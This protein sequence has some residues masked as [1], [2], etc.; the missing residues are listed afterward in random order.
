M[1]KSDRIES[2]VSNFLSVDPTSGGSFNN[3]AVLVSY[4]SLRSKLAPYVDDFIEEHLDTRIVE[5]AGLAA[6]GRFI[7]TAAFTVGAFKK[8]YGGKDVDK[9]NEDELRKLLKDFLYSE[10]KTFNPD[11]SFSGRF[12]R[13]CE[14]MFLGI[15]SV[16]F[17]D[18]RMWTW[19]LDKT[20]LTPHEFVKYLEERHVLNEVVA[21]LFPSIE[22]DR[23]TTDSTDEV[24]NFGD[25]VKRRNGCSERIRAFLMSM[26]DDGT[27]TLVTQTI[28]SSLTEWFEN[29]TNSPI[30]LVPENRRLGVVSKLVSRMRPTDWC[31]P[32]DYDRI[33]GWGLDRTKNSF[34]IKSGNV[35]SELGE[36]SFECVFNIGPFDGTANDSSKGIWFTSQDRRQAD[37]VVQNEKDLLKF[38]TK[39]GVDEFGDNGFFNTFGV[40]SKGRYESSDVV[41]LYGYVLPWMEMPKNDEPYVSPNEYM[42]RTG[43]TASI[44]KF[45]VIAME[46]IDGKWKAYDKFCDYV[47][48]C[49]RSNVD[50]LVEYADGVYKALVDAEFIKES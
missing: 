4:L 35:V 12:D 9:L 20:V 49:Y 46:G 18:K 21:R 39:K 27:R 6:K 2:V 3:E 29:G 22:K 30:A 50:K 5:D 40:T 45:C 48:Y 19:Y 28:Y 14:I 15:D 26:T 33:S 1:T 17:I 31:G 44:K 25:E 11:G 32:A 43:D 47:D 23:Q 8:L 10:S 7:W 24:A 16:T 37:D 13:R 42:M 38:A 41:G 34:T 36:R